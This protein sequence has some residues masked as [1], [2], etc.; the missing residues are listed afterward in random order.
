MK[1]DDPVFKSIPGPLKV[2]QTLNI[3]HNLACR[4]SITFIVLTLLLFL[5]QAV[6]KFAAV[7]KYVTENGSDGSLWWALGSALNGLENL[8]LAILFGATIPPDTSSKRM[9]STSRV[10]THAIRFFPNVQLCL[11][12]DAES[13]LSKNRLRNICD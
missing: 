2:S 13:E 1:T 3:S 11:K 7:C 8:P 6:A 12:F 5:F 9:L 10:S 4:R